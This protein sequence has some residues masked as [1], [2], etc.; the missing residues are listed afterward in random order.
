MVSTVRVPGRGIASTAGG[1]AG[2]GQLRLSVAV[3]PPFGPSTA[4]GRGGDGVAD[5]RKTKSNSVLTQRI[6]GPASPRLGE[7]LLSHATRGRIG[8]EIVS[9]I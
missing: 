9:L 4:G 7:L 3:T 2:V 6:P 5:R 1:E 8:T